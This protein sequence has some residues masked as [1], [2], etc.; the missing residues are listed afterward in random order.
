LGT[1]IDCVNGRKGSSEVLNWQH[2]CTYDSVE[3]LKDCRWTALEGVNIP[4]V[5]TG[6]LEGVTVLLKR[7]NKDGRVS[8]GV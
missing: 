3:E 5:S 6:I 8:Q 2:C 1:A 7:A 4:R